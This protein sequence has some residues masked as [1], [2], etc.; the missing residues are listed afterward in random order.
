M[1]YVLYMATFY[2]YFGINL[3]CNYLQNAVHK[4]DLPFE[5]RTI[6]TNKIKEIL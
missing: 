3:L 5:N 6:M 4:T 1:I 2:Y